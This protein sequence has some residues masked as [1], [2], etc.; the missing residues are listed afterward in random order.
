MLSQLGCLGQGKQFSAKV[1][2]V[3]SG[4]RPAATNRSRSLIGRRQF[5]CTA[6]ATKASQAQSAPL[7]L[8]KPFISPPPLPPSLLTSNLTSYMLLAGVICQ[9]ED[10][11][12][13]HEAKLCED[14]SSGELFRLKSGKDSCRDVIQCTAAVSGFFRK[15]KSQN[16]SLSGP[17]SHPMPPWPRL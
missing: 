1:W 5:P 3:L 16:L 7:N 9:D 10:D 2:S 17:A 12:K 4:F 14:K 13:S 6:A 15:T 11:A 8:L